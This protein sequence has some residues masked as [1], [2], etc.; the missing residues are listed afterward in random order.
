[1]RKA[2]AVIVFVPDAPSSASRHALHLRARF[3]FC[4]DHIWPL[5]AFKMLLMFQG[6]GLRAGSDAAY[7]ASG[8]CKAARAA[9]RA[10]A[11]T[12]RFCSAS[13]TCS[14]RFASAF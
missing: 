14:A 6:V 10:S 7:R 8:A 5:Y 3:G 12:R 2:S 1:M 13:A 4:N 9:R 11:L